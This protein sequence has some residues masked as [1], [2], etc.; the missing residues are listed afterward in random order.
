MN[1]L[2]ASSKWLTTCGVNPPAS[3]DCCGA[4]SHEKRIDSFASP[5]PEDR[6]NGISSVI[7]LVDLDDITHIKL[8][9]LSDYIAM[10]GM[11]EV[12]LDG[13]WG[14]AP[15]ILQLFA[16]SGDGGPQRM[17]AWDRAFLNALYSTSQNSRWQRSAITQSMV[18]DFVGR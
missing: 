5:A 3:G 4:N 6:S 14:D 12:D 17:S 18:R 10:V 2:P 15:T 9:A 11:A 1:A 16:D 13:D 8:G 7:V